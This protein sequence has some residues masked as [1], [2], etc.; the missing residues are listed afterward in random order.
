[1]FSEMTSRDFPFRNGIIVLQVV[2]S[3][4]CKEV[5]AQEFELSY[6]NLQG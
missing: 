6:R 5:M 3:A 2:S 1:M 4:E